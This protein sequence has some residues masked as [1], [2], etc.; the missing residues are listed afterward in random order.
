MFITSVLITNLAVVGA[1]GRIGKQ[2]TEALAKGD[3]HDIIA[4]TRVGS[5]SKITQGVK[6][7]EVNY[8]NEE[9]LV[10]ALER[11]QFLVICLSVTAAP[12]ISGRLVNVAVKAGVSYIM[13]N[14][15]G[16]DS[17]LPIEKDPLLGPKQQKNLKEV[18]DAGLPWI[19]LSTGFWYD[20]S[21][22]LGLQGYGIDIKAK[23]AELC[24]NGNSTVSTS[25]WMR[26]GEAFAAVLSF[27]ETG[28]S[29]CLA[30]YKNKPVY[31]ESFHRATGTTDKNWDVKFESTEQRFRD[32]LAEANA[33]DEKG[34]DKSVYATCWRRMLT[35][36]LPQQNLDEITKAIVDKV[37]V[38]WHP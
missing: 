32:G 5:T 26:C 7:V 31:I 23:K 19:V 20:W 15:H 4:L 13:P 3:K 29:P 34:F 16:G 22:A 9:N 14:V 18:T 28:A 2:Y 35:L 17:D 36:G 10:S 30:D 6:C 1:G 21:L 37:L 8:D 24:G 38:E 27:P 11:Q 25:T 12:D 33:G